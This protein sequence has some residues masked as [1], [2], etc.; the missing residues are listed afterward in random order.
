MS[1]RKVLLHPL[2]LLTASDLITRHRLREF[3]GPVAG[4]LLG[5]VDDVA[6]TVTAEHAFTARL[7]PEFQLD[8]TKDWTTN[9]IQQYKDVHKNPELDV[10]GWFTL[11]PEAGPLR[12]CEAIQ[13]QLQTLGCRNPILLGVHSTAFTSDNAQKGRL[14]VTVYEDATGHDSSSSDKDTMQVDSSLSVTWTSIPHTIETDETEMIAIN[15]V[16]KGAGSAAALLNTTGRQDN[17]ISNSNSKAS[18]SKGEIDDRSTSTNYTPE[19]EDQLTELQTRLNSIRVLQSRLQLLTSFMQ[20]QLSDSTPSPADIKYTQEI[21]SLLTRLSLL[22]P[23][24]PSD[25]KTYQEAALSQAND[26]EISQLLSLLGNDTQGLSELGRKFVAVEQNKS[27]KGK[28]RPSNG[29]ESG[30]AFD[31]IGGFG[32]R[33]GMNMNN[34]G[35]G[36]MLV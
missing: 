33:M 20:T 25:R 13:K 22:T 16:A 8:Q 21:Q 12:E 3:P 6:S 17:G 24:I 1:N 10:V 9:R 34:A 29:K 5:Q 31:A 35:H 4:L 14:P 18:T 15:Y 7:T 19:E 11:C 28:G 32:G 2:V 30:N 36:A 26:V 27:A 23:I